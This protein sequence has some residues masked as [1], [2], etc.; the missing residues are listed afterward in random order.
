MSVHWNQPSPRRNTTQYNAQRL[1][2]QDRGRCSVSWHV[3]PCFRIPS[4]VCT[5][6]TSFLTPYFEV[7]AVYAFLV[8]EFLFLLRWR[9]FN[10]YFTLSII[11]YGTVVVVVV[12]VC[13]C[14]PNPQI[15]LMVVFWLS[16]RMRGADGTALAHLLT[17][18]ACFRTGDTFPYMFKLR[19]WIRFQS[20]DGINCNNSSQRNCDY[21]EYEIGQIAS[22]WYSYVWFFVVV[23]CWGYPKPWNFHPVVP[24]LVAG[25]FGERMNMNLNVNLNLRGW[26]QLSLSS[27][28]RDVI[29]TSTLLYCIYYCD[30]VYRQCGYL[31]IYF[32]SI[33]RCEGLIIQFK[34]NPNFQLSTPAPISL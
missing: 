11:S 15:F 8:L 25:V 28:Q 24:G 10:V 20:G 4:H 27:L 18:L 30:Y 2:Q 16:P 6:N 5:V 32:Y 9:S 1:Q 19:I 21:D 34:S 33:V 29:S 22:C 12:V 7:W 17:L 26:S 23:L 13:V 14:C 3:S 31:S